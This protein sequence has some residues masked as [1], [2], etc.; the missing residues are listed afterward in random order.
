MSQSATYA[1]PQPRHLAILQSLEALFLG[2]FNIVTPFLRPW[3]RRWG[4]QGDEARRTLPGDDLIPQPIWH[5][6]HA[7]Y[8]RATPMQVW[9]WLVQIGDKRGGMYSYVALENLSGC[10]MFDVD[11]IIP[12]FQ[13]LAPGD[14]ISLHP[15]IPALPV[16]TAEPGRCL[17]LGG[18][19]EYN[20]IFKAAVGVTWLFCLDEQPDGTTRLLARWRATYPPTLMMRL[21]FGTPLIEPIHFT[22]ERKMLLGIKARAERTSAR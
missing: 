3:R 14:S 11:R 19:A 13:H 12:E 2:A 22:M 5:A 15:Q 1:Q 20:P 18:P 16:V 17:L 21:S 4:T 10:T 6:T 8:I 9:P 7:V